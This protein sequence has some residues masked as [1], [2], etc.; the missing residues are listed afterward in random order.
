MADVVSAEGAVV[1]VK[2][3]GLSFK[4][5]GRVRQILVVE[6][7]AVTAGQDLASLDTRDLEQ[8]ILQADARLKSAQAELSR[9]QVGAR[10]EEISSA[11]AALAIAQAGVQAAMSAVAIVEGNVGSAEADV[12]TTRSAVAV[13]QG[14]LASAQAAVNSANTHYRDVQDG[15]SQEERAAALAA[16]ESAHAAVRQAQYGY[17][18]IKDRPEAKM[19]PEALILESATIELARAQATHDAVVNHPTASELAVAAALVSEARAGVETAKA[20]VSQARSQVTQAEARVPTVLAQLAQAQA[21]VESARATVQQAQAQLDLVMAGSRAEDIAVAEAAVAQAEAAAA[22]PRNML[23]DAVLKSP[24]D[25]TVGAIM[26]DEGE[27]VSSQMPAV[28]LGNLTQLRIETEDLSEV[29]VDQVSVGQEAKV[30]VDA[31]G[32]ETFTGVVARIAPVATERRGDTVYTVLIDLGVGPES[33]LRWGMSAFVEI[34][35]R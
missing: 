5:G 18:L 9:A 23:E 11:E 27:L 10:P 12:E 35:T 20:Q 32:G 1:P 4:T 30:T 8:A 3:A 6:G 14:N 24:F 29:D 15:A 7:D 16:I 34:E 33:G 25:G 22:E 2:E 19:L 31:L 17:D 13:A 21:Q 26:I 28:R